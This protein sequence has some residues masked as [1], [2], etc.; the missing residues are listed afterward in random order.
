MSHHGTSASAASTLGRGQRR[1]RATFL[2][3]LFAALF[4]TVGVA[5]AAAAP[6]TATVESVS[7]VSYA[8]V[9][10]E[11]TVENASIWVYQIS[12]DGVIWNYT[13]AEGFPGG[14]GPQ[15]ADATLT[16]LKGGTKY[17]VRLIAFGETVGESP[18]PYDSFTTLPVEPPNVVSVHT[19]T[20]DN[21]TAT[22]SGKVLRPA[23]ED[24]AFDAECQFEYITDENFL[25]RNEKQ[26]L[27]I[28]AGAGTYTLS[29]ATNGNPTPQTTAPLPSNASAA[30]VQAG[31]QALPNI[32]A[33]NVTVNG[34]PGNKTGAFPYTI[35]FT[36]ALAA[37][38]VEGISVD[39]ANLTEPGGAETTT[40]TEG[41]AEGFD[42]AS[43][44][45]CVGSPFEAP[46]GEYDA[47]VKLLNLAADKTYHL[48]LSA[49]DRG[50]TDFL[51]APNFATTSVISAQTLSP[52]GVTAAKASLSGRVNAENA[53]LTYQFKWGAT[54][55]Y[56]NIVPAAPESL[57]T[58]DE[59]PHVVA[60]EITGLAPGTVYHYR[61]VAT[62]TQT[63][64][65][66]EGND[67]VFQTLAVGPP[68][69]CP[70]ESSRVGN[71]AGLPDCRA[72]E[73]ASPGLNGAGI[74]GPPAELPKGAA[75]SNGD[76]VI[77]QLKDA[78]LDSHG[79]SVIDYVTAEK[80]PGGGWATRSLDAPLGYPVP[81][82]FSV[83]TSMFNADHTE[84]E[85]SS[86]VPPTKT[87]ENPEY[88]G[89]NVD[90]YFRHAD[91]S[92][93][94]ITKKSMFGGII[95]A[96]A[97]PNFKH[98]FLP[99]E[100]PQW[101]NDPGGIYEYAVDAG[102]LRHP[103][104]LPNGT[105]AGD[106]SI[107]SGGGLNPTS[108]DGEILV[109]YS[110][111]QP[112]LRIADSE[113]REIAKSRKAVPDPSGPA[114][115]TP[116]GVTP[117]GNK[118]YFLSRTELTED[119]NTGIK[120][121]GN[122]LYS[123]DVAS[124]E[125]TDLTVDNKPA[126]FETG[127]NVQSVVAIN[128]D[129]SYVY[130]IATGNLAPGAISGEPNLYVWHGDQITFI[131]PG[132]GYGQTY[133]TPDGTHLAFTSTASL[134]GYDN[135]SRKH[136]TPEPMAFEY[137][138]GGGIVCGSCRPDG[139]SPNGPALFPV[140]AGYLARVGN[141]VLSD[142]GSRMFFQSADRILPQASNQKMNVYEY[143]KGETHLLT[144]GDTEAPVYM[145]DASASGDDV[146]ITANEEL[147]PE[148]EGT[149]TSIY[150]VRVNA[151][152]VPPNTPTPCTGENCRGSKT[153]APASLAPASSGFEAPASIVAP[154][155][156]RG[157]KTK[158]QLR[159]YV[160]ADGQLRVSGIGLKTAAKTAKAPGFLTISAVLRPAA[161][162]KRNVRGVFKSTAELLFTP[163]SGE[164]T[165][166]TV[167]LQ[168]ETATKKAAPRKAASKKGGK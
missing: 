97:S 11:G 1:P 102:A 115:P 5:T 21:H 35:T 83:Q 122:D 154:K 6:A 55:A 89:S 168:F 38:N 163:G 142:D 94:R 48:R 166:A 111:G 10:L 41:H 88:N 22:L 86:S 159:V 26:R 49:T 135:R 114:S 126:D 43:V 158:V 164:T 147:N 30:A 64:E 139:S 18:P 129:G 50:G 150:D 59:A 136:N 73:F 113:T 105:T 157:K 63:G 16:G 57:A 131:G 128:R 98:L 108:D 25:A 65:V 68:E 81:S 42:G 106:A 130:F 2:A 34:G 141:R 155:S 123:Y 145:L 12:T 138:Y 75:Q 23:N 72:I 93:S 99:I 15:P 120:D 103:G 14:E 54:A 143:T 27:T 107:P 33:G 153:T 39:P 66:A 69:S 109:F 32:G 4:L 152:L 149:N 85:I 52:S 125:L 146:Y 36:G 70:N 92:W 56:G 47:A 8:S 167:A 62:N 118:A 76:S 20:V 127:A 117:D 90:L 133:V 160:P 60:E 7:E 161:I 116:L 87:L 67:Q 84:W 74:S 17:F 119:A 80:K 110:G 162:K 82:F 40:L 28:K 124:G 61:I 144:P 137:T 79:S 134:T 46:G 13:S 95:D 132:E 96:Y 100:N 91:G 53:P 112:Y 121:A 156:M 148:A 51:V 44:A 31:L 151:D 37:K 71:S 77:F 58:V 29:F 101:E 24:H 78:P 104:V 19:D 140:G 45:N 165:R 3:L 9:H